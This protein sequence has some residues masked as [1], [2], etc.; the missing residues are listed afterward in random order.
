MAKRIFT[1]KFSNLQTGGAQRKTKELTSEQARSQLR[2]RK[3]Q[4][5]LD[6]RKKKRFPV[7]L[8]RVAVAKGQGYTPVVGRWT[9]FRLARVGRDMSKNL[10]SSR[11]T[12]ISP[13]F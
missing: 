1:P 3:T 11:R 2:C 7:R 13:V 10:I 4:T 9:G 12:L 5:R 6:G 8:A